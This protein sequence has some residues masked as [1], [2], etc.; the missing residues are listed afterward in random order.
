MWARGARDRLDKAQKD[1]DEASNE[2]MRLR[3]AV[4][5]ARAE[6]D[7]ARGALTLAMNEFACLPVGEDEAWYESV[8]RWRPS[9]EKQPTTPDSGTWSR[10][11]EP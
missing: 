2:A 1:A 7:M 10:P 8:R 3:N 11:G 4:H 6:N 9:W 5:A